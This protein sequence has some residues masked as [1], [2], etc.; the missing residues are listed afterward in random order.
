MDENWYIENLVKVLISTIL[1]PNSTFCENQNL[2]FGLASIPIKSSWECS[3]K[4]HDIYDNLNDNL[5]DNTCH[6]LYYK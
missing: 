4:Y 5:N 3:I 2:Q 1:I 6:F